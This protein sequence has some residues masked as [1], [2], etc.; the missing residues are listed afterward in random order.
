MDFRYPV[1]QILAASCAVMAVAGAA[2]NGPPP[3]RSGA[4]TVSP[5]RIDLP[6]GEDHAELTLSNALDRAS[7]V[8][9]RVFAWSQ[10]N[11]LDRF[12]PTTDFVVSPSIF[13]MPPQSLQ[14]FHIVRRGPTTGTGEGRYRIVI[15]QLP[16]PPSGVSQAAVTRLQMTLPLFSG[17][18]RASPASLTASLAGSRLTIANSGGRT[19]RIGSLAV[20]A[21]DGNRWPIALEVGRYVHGQSSLTYQIAGFDCARAARVRIVGMVDRTG[22]DAVPQT[23]C[24]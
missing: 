7:A 3:Q 23:S 9:V 13:R 22:F 11:G 8:Q 21:A 18:E 17:S 5:L 12:S 2:Q 20:V 6:S 1:A 14:Q 15:D 4:F 16:E 24:P 10:E 19:A